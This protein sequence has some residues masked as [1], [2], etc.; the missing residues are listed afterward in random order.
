MGIKNKGNFVNAEKPNLAWKRKVNAI[1]SKPFGM[2]VKTKGK[3][4]SERSIQKKSIQQSTFTKPRQNRQK[5]NGP[6]FL[7]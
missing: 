6:H 7:P 5:E 4:V 1:V 3:N 2:D